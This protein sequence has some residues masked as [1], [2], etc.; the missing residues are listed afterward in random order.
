MVRCSAVDPR[1]NC[2]LFFK[3]VIASTSV[4]TR[5]RYTK[6]FII[7]LCHSV[8]YSVY[9][10][11]LLVQSDQ[12]NAHK[13]FCVHFVGPFVGNFCMYCANELLR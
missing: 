7:R 10:S 1:L 5:K 3:S 9:S 12:Q 2:S 4:Q 8:R 13:L 6:A 11:V